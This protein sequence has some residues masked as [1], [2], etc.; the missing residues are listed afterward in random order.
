MNASSYRCSNPPIYE[1]RV[2]SGKEKATIRY[3]DAPVIHTLLD[4]SAIYL[5][6]DQKE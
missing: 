3:A 4:D 1:K 5:M 6:R 2:V